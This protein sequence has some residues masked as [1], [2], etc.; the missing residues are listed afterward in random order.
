LIA[1]QASDDGYIL[2]VR[3]LPG[4][5]RN[6]IRGQQDGALK[7]AVTQV[8]EKGKANMALREQ[9]AKWLQLRK[10]QVTLIAGATQA[11]KRF[12]VREVPLATLQQRL[13]ELLAE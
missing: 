4:A 11:Q 9:L 13:A 6:E 2:N 3:A 8:A 12:L 10:S 7:I 1:I 5:R